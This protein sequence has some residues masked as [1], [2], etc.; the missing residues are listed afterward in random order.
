MVI[1]VRGGKAY[2]YGEEADELADSGKPSLVEPRADSTRRRKTTLQD[3]P[4]LFD[5]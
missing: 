3:Q 4:T 5:L 2:L 1:A